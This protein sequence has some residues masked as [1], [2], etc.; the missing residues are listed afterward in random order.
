MMN[1]IRRQLKKL[2][3]IQREKCEFHIVKFIA[4]PFKAIKKILC[5]LN[6]RSPKYPNIFV[7]QPTNDSYISFKTMNN[8]FYY[9]LILVEK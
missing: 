9:K 4:A 7:P 5:H 1:I 2:S 6:C 3:C 8:Y